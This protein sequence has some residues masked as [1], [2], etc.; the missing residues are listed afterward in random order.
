MSNSIPLLTNGSVD[1]ASFEILKHHETL[2]LVR[3]TKLE[4]GLF[5]QERRPDYHCK[6]LAKCNKLWSGF[7]REVVQ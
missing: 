3:H 7:M 6:C 5:P 1:E 4:Q 2:L